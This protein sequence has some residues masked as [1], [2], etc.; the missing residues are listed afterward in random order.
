[1][2]CRKCKLHLENEENNGNIQVVLA[3]FKT[4]LVVKGK[5]DGM[6]VEHRREV[7]EQ[8]LTTDDDNERKPTKTNE[9]ADDR[10]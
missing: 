6:H 10:R 9:R 7:A 3:R 8:F 4:N 2:L 5:V 1:M